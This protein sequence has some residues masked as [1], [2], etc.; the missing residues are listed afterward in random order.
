M[1][2]Y[3]RLYGWSFMNIT[4]GYICDW[5]EGPDNGKFI[6]LIRSGYKNWPSVF[7]GDI[8]KIG[9]DN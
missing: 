5:N 8:V 2:F 6:I 9:I 3:I 4:L 1:T 7:K